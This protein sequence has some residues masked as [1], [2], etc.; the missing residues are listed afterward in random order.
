MCTSTITIIIIMRPNQVAPLRQQK[1]NLIQQIPAQAYRCGS[2]SS[3]SAASFS[4]R[5]FYF[6][7]LRNKNPSSAHFRFM[8][9]LTKSSLLL[10]QTP[11]D[12]LLIARFNSHLAASPSPRVDQRT[13]TDRRPRMTNGRTPGS[14]GSVSVSF[15]RGQEE[16]AG[17]IS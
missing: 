2:P 17:N 8:G 10:S 9:K 15:D 12:T 11:S 5:V 14:S 13:A 4:P 3:A 16:G 7:S 6:K 1:P